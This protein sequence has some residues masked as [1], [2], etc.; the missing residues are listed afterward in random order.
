VIKKEVE[1]LVK[2][3]DLTIEIQRIWNVKTKVTPIITGVTGTIS[4]SF[5]KYL[6]NIPVKHDI[7][8]LHKTAILGTVHVLRKVL[9]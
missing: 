9:M 6:T 1:N 8:E 4:I 7:K 5:R 2:Y 3:K